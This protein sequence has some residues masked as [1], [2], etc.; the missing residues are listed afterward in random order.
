ATGRDGTET[1]DN[2]FTFGETI[3]PDSIAF[4]AQFL[5]TGDQRQ[6][7]FDQLKIN[8]AE[9]TVTFKDWNGDTLKTETVDHGSDATAPADPAREG[10]TFS[11]W[12]ADYTNVTANLT[13]NAQYTINQYTI[14]FDSAGG[15]AVDAITQDYGTVVTAPADPTRT[16]YTFNGW[17]P[18]VPATMQAE[19]ITLTAQWTINQYTLTYTAGANGSVNG[20]LL[21]TLIVEYD[22][23]GTTVTAMPD[24]GYHFVQ[25]SDGVLT[26]ARLDQ[27]V[28][29]DI[30]VTAEFAINQYT[31]IFK[32]WDGTELKV[33]TV[34][35]GSDATAPAN[36]TRTGY[37]FTGWN[38]DYTNVVADLT[39]NAEYSDNDECTIGTDNCHEFA[40]CENTIGSFTCTCNEGYYGDG[41]TCTEY[42][43]GVCQKPEEIVTLPYTH[44]S[45][46]TGRDSSLNDYGL[47]CGSVEVSSY[48]SPDF[49]Y[50]L[51]LIAGQ[52]VE[53]TLTP[54]EG[55]DAVLAVIGTCGEDQDCVMYANENPAAQSEVLYIEAVSDATYFIVVE[56]AVESSYGSYTLD[57]KEWVEET[58]DD[59]VPD[60][61]TVDEDVIDED[62][63]DD[64]IV[65]ED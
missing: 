50:S 22:A 26:A 63:V 38:A 6:P 27:N 20:K 28:T 14:T 3:A 34:D 16:G 35:H 37:S 11:S 42:P 60:E 43:L 8:R 30:D 41:V 48:L 7:Y 36:P 18:A 31:I 58:D 53:I 49:V 4:Y 15:S 21:E 57:V 45:T 62:V 24:E 65:D 39:V 19:N 17:S 23:S 12:D 10:Y 46:T 1:Y 52:K 9:Y 56:G 55:F 5:D 64:D 44:N 47:N 25:W 61:D 54:V 59:I 51:D 13:V 40:T 33:E 32:D 2:T 29:E